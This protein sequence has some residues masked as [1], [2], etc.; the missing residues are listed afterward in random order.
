[1]D[2]VGYTDPVDRFFHAF[3]GTCGE[4]PII[5]GLVCGGLVF[6]LVCYIWVANIVGNYC[7]SDIGNY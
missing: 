7:R 3:I 4:D 5:M 2:L 6:R 1:M